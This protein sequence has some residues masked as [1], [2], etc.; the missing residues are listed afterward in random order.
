[1]GPQRRLKVL[2]VIPTYNEEEALPSVV[3]EAKGLFPGVDF[4]LVDDGSTD[5]TLEVARREGLKVLRLPFRLGIGGAVQAGYLFGLREGYEVVL[6]LDGD[7]Q[8]K[9]QELK[10]LLRPLARGEADVVVGSRFLFSSGHHSTCARRMGI[11]FFRVLLAL[12]GLRN[13]SDP[14][15][16]F[17]GV[18]HKAL[19]VFCRSFASDYPEVEALVLAKKRGLRV[20][21]VGVLMEERKG[22]KSSI[23]F[24]QALYYMVKVTV[25]SLL[26]MMRRE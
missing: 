11:R 4:L 9:P 7:G 18:N 20:K 13:L 15:S 1:M 14:T 16:G 17:V 23:Y 12:S 6:R 10:K 5:S 25:A 19:E 24:L 22:G 8:H 21:E 2:V 3:K 26:G